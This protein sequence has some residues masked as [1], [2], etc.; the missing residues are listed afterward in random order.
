M[1]IRGDWRQFRGDP[2]EIRPVYKLVLLAAVVVAATW[3]VVSAALLVG[4]ERAAG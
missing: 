2:P 4:M 3:V 1:M